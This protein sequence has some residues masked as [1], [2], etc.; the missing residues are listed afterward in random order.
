MR[1]EPPT[2]MESL[3]IGW[4]IFWRTAGSF[5]ILHFTINV[6]LVFLFPEL[7]RTSPSLWIAL[8]PLVVVS[9]LCLFLVMPH[10]ARVLVRRDFRGFHLRF[11]HDRPRYGTT[12]TQVMRL[13]R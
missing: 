4:A 6:G 7:L 8:M 2:Y 5:I 10:V 3:K 9:A 11:V 12:T 1:I 13:A